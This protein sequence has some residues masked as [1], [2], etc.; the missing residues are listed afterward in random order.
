MGVTKSTLST[1]ATAGLFLVSE[2]RQKRQKEKLAALW[3]LA[4]DTE[5]KTSATI[6]RRSFTGAAAMMPQGNNARTLPT[7]SRLHHG[8]KRTRKIN[9]YDL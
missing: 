6:H 7:F 5:K 1:I 3:L 9:D 8:Q 4:N 2:I